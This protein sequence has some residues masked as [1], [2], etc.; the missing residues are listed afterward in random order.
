MKQENADLSNKL[1]KEKVQED[2]FFDKNQ[3]IDSYDALQKNLPPKM[4]ESIRK[5]LYGPKADEITLRPETINRANK[6]DVEVKSY[7]INC[8]K[9]Q[10]VAPRLVKVAAIQNKIVVPASSP[11]AEQ[12]KALE[13]RIKD[14][15][16]LAALEKANV[17]CMQ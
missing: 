8:E 14:I 2:V 1:N 3:L 10:T 11:V 7:K 17:V 5:I 9:Q 16:E 15:I 4:F 13:D 12:K 6:L